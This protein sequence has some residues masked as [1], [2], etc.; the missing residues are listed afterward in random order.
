MASPSRFASVAHRWARARRWLLLGYPAPFLARYK[1]SDLSTPDRAE[2]GDDAVR[3]WARWRF[4]EPIDEG[5][6]RLMSVRVDHGGQG[7]AMGIPQALATA[8]VERDRD[9]AAALIRDSARVARAPALALGSGFARAADLA[10][11][12]G[13]ARLVDETELQAARELLAITE[14][15]VRDVLT[16]ASLEGGKAP[17]CASVSR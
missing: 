11:E 16:W 10:A 12:R 3:V 17:P 2:D 7:G 13:A 15:P 5:L 9:V 8:A 14:E 6:A 4:A 1:P